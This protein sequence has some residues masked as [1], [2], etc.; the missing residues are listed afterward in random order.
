M[1]ARLRNQ[2]GEG[3]QLRDVSVGD[4][5][6]SGRQATL[7]RH[8]RRAVAGEGAAQPPLARVVGHG[9]RPPVAELGM[10]RGEV[11]ECRVGGVDRREAAVV[12]A[13]HLH[14]VVAGRAADHLPQP[15]GAAGSAGLGAVAAFDDRDQGELPGEVAFFD[16]LDDVGQ[17]RQGLAQLA[18]EAGRVPRVAAAPLP[19]VVTPDAHRRREGR[20]EALEEFAA[21]ADPRRRRGG[22]S[23]L[24]TGRCG[25]WRGRW[26]E[27]H[28][29]GGFVDLRQLGRPVRRRRG[30]GRAAH[31]EA[32]QDQDEQGAADQAGKL[33]GRGTGSTS[34]TRPFAAQS[35]P[36]RPSN[37]PSSRR[38]EPLVGRCPGPSLAA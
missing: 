22:G 15:G 29:L 5:R 35:R 38:P 13:P 23:R 12:A 16:G 24:G 4:V 1:S 37:S 27:G 19:I 10:E 7:A 2:A 36:C 34:G 9:G 33:G 30:Q 17:Q 8:L 18:F 6:Q 32:R 31:A 20:G 25:A 11:T 21:V 28:R 14:P 3:V 26:R